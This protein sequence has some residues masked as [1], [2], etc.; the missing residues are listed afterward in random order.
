LKLL[1]NPLGKFKKLAGVKVLANL[2][3]ITEKME[4]IVTQ[5]S[6]LPHPEK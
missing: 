5:D 4:N 6:Y 3:F 1:I 2:V